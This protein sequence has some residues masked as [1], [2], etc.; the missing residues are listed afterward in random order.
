MNDESHHHLVCSKWKA[1]TDIG[2]KEPGL[3]SKHNKLPGGFMVERC[4]IDVIG[5]CAKCQQ[6]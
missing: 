2:G 6:A 3:V 5:I 4:A 1:I